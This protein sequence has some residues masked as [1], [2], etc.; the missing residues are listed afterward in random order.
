M[1]YLNSILLCTALASLIVIGG[2]TKSVDVSGTWTGSASG[3]NAGR[4]GTSNVQASFQG[5]RRGF[6]GTLTWHNS[7]G[8]WGLMEG[9]TLTI[10]NGTVSGNK[11]SFAANDN[12]PG[13]TVM[14]T[15]KGTVEGN[16]MKGTGDLT[17]GSV[18]GGDTYLGDM[19][20]T[21]K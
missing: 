15:F 20:L 3:Q 5:T 4:T 11:V 8:P 10:P 12:L 7:T 19:E 1:R 9:N 6:T 17:V 16:T 2:C 13:G 14:L 18:M 21:K